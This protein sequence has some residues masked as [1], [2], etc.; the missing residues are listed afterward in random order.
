MLIIIVLSCKNRTTVYF[1][2]PVF[3]YFFKFILWRGQSFQNQKN[4]NHCGRQK[5]KRIALKD[6]E[7][8]V[9]VSALP[10]DSGESLT[11]YGL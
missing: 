7:D 8:C 1:L 11:F 9:Q 6:S 10:Y 3:S 4:K 2:P 5:N